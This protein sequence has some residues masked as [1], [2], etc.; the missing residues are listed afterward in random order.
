MKQLVTLLLA[1]VC[2]SC[3]DSDG[4]TSVDMRSG[5]TGLPSFPNSGLGATSSDCVQYCR[6]LFAFCSNIT[7]FIGSN[8]RQASPARC[9]EACSASEQTVAALDAQGC[10]EQWSAY[11]ACAVA[12]RDEDCDVR[13]CDIEWGVYRG[14][15][16]L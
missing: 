11:E 3:G 6:D 1:V 4:G 15:A 12:N 13:G 7:V 14:C 8:G 10:R 9:A 16:G 2:L 5:T